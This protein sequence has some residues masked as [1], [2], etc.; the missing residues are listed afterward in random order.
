MALLTDAE[1][2]AL[3]LPTAAAVV[4]PLPV[5]LRVVLGTIEAP[6]YA[7]EQLAVGDRLTWPIPGEGCTVWIGDYQIG[8]GVVRRV[9]SRLAVELRTWG[10]PKGGT[11]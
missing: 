2:A 5:T 7:W 8:T 6:E 4:P 10:G 11:A 1:R 9:G 3:T